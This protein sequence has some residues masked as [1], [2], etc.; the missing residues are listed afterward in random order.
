MKFKYIMILAVLVTMTSGAVEYRDFMS[1]DGKAIRGKILRVDGKKKTVTIERDT[2]KSATVPIAVFSAEDQSYIKEWMKFEGVRSN[3]K[4]KVSCE[5]RTFE[6]WTKE[7]LG[8][9][10]YTGGGS[11]TDQVV[12]KHSF[13]KIGYD[14]KIR[15][16][17]DYA[18]SGL[19]LQY[20]IYYEQDSGRGPKEGVKFGTAELGTIISRK[21]LELS[22]APVEVFKYESNA[23]FLNSRVNKGEVKGVWVRICAKDKE[24][25]LMVL[26]QESL[27]S[28]I[29]KS[30]AWSDSSKAAK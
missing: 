11:E 2:R 17:N 18:L 14:V 15:N 10:T 20:C 4:F 1:A 19:T 16:N 5:R 3:S 8:T 29:L 23:E 22:T 7:K 9:I 12:G 6:T 21:E 24:G 27:P 26:R 28:G 25:D 30:K 13:K